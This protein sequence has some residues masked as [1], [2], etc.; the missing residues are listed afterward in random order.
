MRQIVYNTSNLNTIF[1]KLIRSRKRAL[2]GLCLILFGL[3]AFAGSGITYH[4][5]ILKPDGITPV[6]S[7]TTQFRIQVRTPGTENC[8]LWEEQQTKDLSSSNG[9]FS[10]TIAD[11]SEPTLIANTLPY[12]LERIFSNRTNFTSLTGCSSGS[13]YN[14]SSVDGRSLVVFFKENPT[15]PWEQMPVTKINFVPLALNSVQ[16]EGYSSSEFL[17]VDPASSYTTL[18]PTQVNSLVDII[19]GATAQYLK[20]ATTF[21]GDVSGTYNATSVDKIKGVTVSSTAP[22][23]GQVLKFDG[24]NWSPGTDNTGSSVVDSSYSAKGIVQINTDQATSGLFIS[25]GVLAMPNVISAGGPVGGASIVPIITYDQKGRLTAVTSATVNDT[26]KLPLAGGTMTGSID[27]GAQN[28]TNATSVAATNFSGRNLVL[29]D[30]GSNTVTVKTPSSLAASYTL[31]L[32]PDHGTSNQVLTTDGSGV[33]S[34]TTPSTATGTITGVTAGTGLTGGGTSG[35]VTLNI[36]TVPVANGGTG[37]TTYTDGQLLI[38]NSTGN[39]L[40]KATLTAGS[41]VSITNGNGSIT[42]AATGSG[43]SVTSVGLSLPSEITVTNSPVTTAGTLTGAWAN[44]TTNKVFASPNGSTGTPSFRSLVSADLPTVA[45]AQGGTGATSFSANQAVVANGTG[46]ALTSFTCSSTQ[47]LGF[48][49]SGNATCVAAGPTNAFVNGGNSFGANSVLGNSDNFDLD[50][51]TNNINRVI[52]AAGGNVAIGNITPSSILDINGAMTERGMAAPA[53]SAAGQGVMYF[54]STSNTFKISQN[55]GAYA[56]ILTSAS[57]TGTIS[58]VTAGTG[59]TGGGTTGTVTLNVDVGTT[60]GKIVQVQTGGKL[61]VLDGSNLTSLTATNLSGVVPVVNGGTGQSTYTDGQLLIGNTTGNTL[62]KATLTAGSGVSITNGNGSIT[63]AATGSGGTVTS[64]GLSLPSE[65][66]VT[67]S[68]V[69]ASGTLTGAWAS[70]GANKVFAAPNG[71]AGTPSFRSLVSADLPT[72]AVAQGGTGATSFSANQAVVANGTGTAL[73]SFTCSSTQVLGFDVSGNATCV[74]VAG[75]SGFVNGGNSFGAAANLGTNDNY[76]LNIKTNNSTKMTIQAGGNVGIGATSPVDR[77]SFGVAPTASATHAL[78]N[79]SNTALSSGNS[80]GT[81]IGANPSSNSADYINFQLNNTTMFRVDNNGNVGANNQFYSTGGG[82]NTYASSG[83]GTAGPFSN[84]SFNAINYTTGDGNNANMTFQVANTAGKTQGA[85]ITAVAVTGASA[86]T[87]A[88]AFG[89]SDGATTYSEK[90]RIDSNGRVGIGNTA[91]AYKLDVAGDINITGN[92][93]VNGTAIGGG[94]GT[95]TSVTSANTDIAVATTTTTPVL[96]LNSGTG[97]NQIVKLDGSAKLPAVDGSALTNLNASNLASGTVPVAR[98]GTGQTT[99]TDGQLLIGNTTGNTLSKATLTA[100]S[101]ISVT[102]GNGSIT[103]A[104]TNNGTVTSVG[105]SLPSEITVTNSPVTA[106]GT[107]TG[108]W[109]SETA[110]KVFAAPNGSAGTPIFRSLVSADLPTVAVAQGG[111]GATSFSANQMV[112]A[113]GTGTALTS[114]TCSSTQVLGFDVSGNA[115]C[116]TVAGSGGFINGGNSFGAASSLGNN[117]N[118]DLTVKTNNTARMTIQAGGNVGIGIT[119]P[120]AGLDVGTN[121]AASKPGLKVDGTWYTAGSTTTNKPQLLVEPTGTTSTAWNSLGTGLGVNAASGFSGNLMD[122]QVNGASQMYVDQYGDIYGSDIYAA[123]AFHSNSGSYMTRAGYDLHLYANAGTTAGLTILNSNNNVGIGNTSPGTA[124]DI[125]GAVTERGMAAPAVSSAGQGVMYFDSSSNTFKISQNGSV[126]SNIL[127][128]ATGG[129]ITGVTAGTGLTGGGTSGTVTL[130][131]GTVPVANGGTGQTTYTDGQ[132]LIG[133]T[134]GNTL[135]KATLTAGSG[136]SVT[137]GNGSITIAATNNGTVTSVG[138]SLPSEITVTNSPVT[139]SGTL[140]GAWANQTTNKFFA[141]PNGSTGTPS[142]RAIA[143]ADLPTV[144]VAQGGTGATSFTANQA[145]VANGTGSALTSF[146]CSSTQV[147]GFNAS[148]YAT[149]VTLGAAISSLTAAAATNTIDN[150]TYAQTWNWSTATT[151]NPL[152]L[153]ANALTTGSILS[154]TT[155]DNSLNST[156]GLLNVAN[157][158]TSTSGMVARIQSNST[159]GSGVT[160]LASGKVGIGS[161]APVDVLSIG[162]APTASATHALV[163]LSNTALSSANGNGTYLGANPSSYSGDFINFQVG[164]SNMFVVGNNGAATSANQFTS[165]GGGTNVYASSGSTFWPNFGNSSFNAYNYNYADG[166]NAQVGFMVTNTAGKT[167][168]AYM[169]AVAVTG[170]SSYTPALVFGASTGSAAYQERMRIDST[171]TVGIATATPNSSY[172]LDVSG[173]M[174]STSL[175]VW[176]SDNTVYTT[177]SSSSNAPGGIG[178]RTLNMSN[179]DSNMASVQLLNHNANGNNQTAYIGT[180]SVTGAGYTPTIVIGQQTGANAYAERMRIDTS[181]NVGIGATSPAATLDVN[182]AI[183]SAAVSN[184]TTTIDFSTGNL[185]YTSASCG[186]LTLNN[187]KSGGT[188]TLAVQGASG[189][190]CSFT[191]WTGSGTGSLTVKAGPATLAQTAGNHILFTFL[192]MGS[193]VYVASVN[194]Y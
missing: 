105:L 128:A 89:T 67:N 82:N 140:T 20:P 114:F 54:D 121:G 155:S 63:I 55:G 136:I 194:G 8:L 137:N 31:T 177:T 150:T 57:G 170:S 163:N 143:S 141:A 139:T 74:T 35:T 122:L 98:G 188:Y 3:N 153:T 169:S 86:Y 4:G 115:T 187:L 64:V 22:T 39:T 15:D 37:Q 123:S 99:Y 25:G 51:K 186:A 85:Y 167:Q 173:G 116:V 1:I 14:P 133:N 147:L 78:V 172:K 107:L 125:S 77:L 142:F 21:S 12:T 174:R 52:V 104:A 27:M 182:G 130:N 76:D 161:T 152:T 62:S 41:G 160:V 178:S 157:T 16:L 73:T 88:L 119:S 156:S 18:T 94:S 113:N 17:K 106:S 148:G 189:G 84:S 180:V 102:N 138:L 40:T 29:N 132:L 34:W 59:L 10:I 184:S 32:P 81:Y 5:K 159:A 95:V 120:G 72:V 70:E 176:S 56:D 53:V 93:R 183:K 118:Y 61:P 144:A 181:G 58:G 108:A 145:V 165:Q 171:G 97:N 33:L 24:T 49:V 91:P 129:T 179:T 191:A 112:V 96:T 151:Q 6:N 117:D 75:S 185:Q 36:G 79:L 45:V 46:S 111:T 47:V 9:A 69:T 166:G 83:S 71:S 19:T 100:G 162:T 30:S 42:I 68:P 50:I 134:T 65:I 190:T 164:N 87:P 126:Y 158:G 13:G 11:T 103:I 127:T 44:Q 124:L 192:V 38:G 131:I 193:Y 154:V 175:D 135:S 26:T 149:C 28:I 60:A 43:G 2:W 23:T 7:T 110:N 146:S 66:T 92:F 109:A 48:D 90:M 101:G 80:S 168:E